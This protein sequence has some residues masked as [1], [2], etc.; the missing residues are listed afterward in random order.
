MP[1]FY[2]DHDMMPYKMRC[3]YENMLGFVLG[4]KHDRWML[5][6][7]LVDKHDKW[8]LEFVMW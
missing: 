1:M 8:V 6:F 5:G 3:F 7:V 4:D 2:L